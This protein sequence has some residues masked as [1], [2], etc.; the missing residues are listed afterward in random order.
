MASFERKLSNSFLFLRP[1]L[2]QAMTKVGPLKDPLHGTYPLNE[3]GH[4]KDVLFL[5]DHLQFTVEGAGLEDA[6]LGRLQYNK[7]K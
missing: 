1:F 4:H 2:I 3:T 5:T 6:G 7:I